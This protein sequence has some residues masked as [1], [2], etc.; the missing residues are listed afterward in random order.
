MPPSV[1]SDAPP[2]SMRWVGPQSVTSWPNSRCQMSSSGKPLS[3]NAPQAAIIAPP[4]GAHQSPPIWIAV[5]VGRSVPAGHRQ[6][7]RDE[8]AEEPDEDQ[9]VGRVGERARVAAVVD[10]QGD[11]PVHAEHGHEQRA[12]EQH[13]RDGR[14]RGQTRLSLGPACRSGSGCRCGRLRWPAIRRITSAVATMAPAVAPIASPSAAPPAGCVPLACANAGVAVVS[15]PAA[16]V[17]A[18]IIM[19][20]MCL[21]PLWLE[22]R[23]GSG[24]S[25]NGENLT[26]RSVSCL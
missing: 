14:P 24:S 18:A 1:A 13:R 6:H 25:R 22:S 10:V 19:R 20:R 26:E 17:P 16:T 9:V 5:L 4:T 23:Y 7:A 15:M 8:H 2:I 12:A 21:A 11:V 3:A